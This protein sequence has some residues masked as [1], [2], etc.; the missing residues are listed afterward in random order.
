MRLLR[1][2]AVVATVGLAGCSSWNPLV[3]MGIMSEPANKPTPLAKIDEKVALKPA[4]TA[5][6]GKAGDFVLA[7]DVEAGRVYAAAGDG[8]ITVLEEDTGKVVT[9]A[10][11]KK[12]ISGGVEFADGHVLVGTFKGE[13]LSLDPAGKTQWKSQVQGEVIAPPATAKGVVVV[14]TADGRIFGLDAADGKRKWVYQR[15]AP[16]LLLRTAAGVLATGGDVLAGYP[17]GKLVALDVD[18]GKLT[19]E[20]TVAQPRGTTELE[21]IADVAG[22]PLL[23][24]GT[25]CAAAFQGKVACFDIQSRNMIWSK[26]ISSAKDLVRDAKNIYVVDDRGAVH[27]LD[28]STGASAWSNDKLLYRR[29][30]SPVV[31]RALVLVGD[32]LGYV[33]ALSPEDGAIVGRMATDGSAIHAIVPVAGGVLIQ[34]AKGQLSMVRL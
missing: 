19:W 10:E 29:L 30:T 16:A 12:P 34:T 3:S 26:D 25:V 1:C 32:G 9:R 6:V 8:T 11:L 20:V 27:A 7:P 5:S 4:W 33:H 2:V 17:N 22:R 15:P 21:R 13:V 14:R 23:D 28:K 31:T 24:G 18:D